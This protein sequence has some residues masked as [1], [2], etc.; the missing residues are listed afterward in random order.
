ML[1]TGNYHHNKIK[2]QSSFSIT[3]PFFKSVN[4]EETLIDYFRESSK[5]KRIHNPL[6]NVLQKF[7]IVNMTFATT[8]ILLKFTIYFNVC[9]KY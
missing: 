6:Y 9:F 8:E 2:L 5:V 4:R 1:Q 7:S 3:E